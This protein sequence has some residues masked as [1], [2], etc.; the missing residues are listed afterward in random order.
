MKPLEKIER[1]AEIADSINYHEKQL[2]ALYKR[3]TRN[4]NM[5]FN[6]L[7]FNDHI[8]IYKRLLRI[9]EMKY[10]RVLTEINEY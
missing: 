10:K 5:G 9:L 2:N 8:E 3:K 7:W 6:T 1:L 4:R